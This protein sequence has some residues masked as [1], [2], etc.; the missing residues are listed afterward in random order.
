MKKVTLFVLLAFPCLLY[1]QFFTGYYESEPQ[2]EGFDHF[3][4]KHRHGDEAKYDGIFTLH[5]YIGH[6]EAWSQTAI[7]IHGAEAEGF[8]E[9]YGEGKDIL[10][11]HKMKLLWDGLEWE[12][13]MLGFKEEH[14]TSF[15]V[16][17][18]VFSDESETELLEINQYRWTK[19]LHLSKK[20]VVQHH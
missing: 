13:F 9:K 4:I 11:V 18:E 16:V 7:T 12:F 6:N 10:S 14:H 20:S 3:W 17:E 8:I 2:M 1:A 19:A 5:A 15:I